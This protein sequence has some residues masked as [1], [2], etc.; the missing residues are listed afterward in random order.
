MLQKMRH[1][2]K[3]KIVTAVGFGLMV[4]ATAGIALMDVTGS[5]RGGVSQTHVAKVDGKKISNAEFS[6]L[7]QTYLQRE[8]IPPA[9]AARAGIPMQILQQE[10]NGRLF[11]RAAYDLGIIPDD[12]TAA[13]QIKQLIA[14]LT[15]KGASQKDALTQFLRAYGMSEKQLVATIKSDVATE[16]LASLLSSGVSVPKQLL[17]DALQYRHEWRRGEYFTLSAADVEKVGEPSEEDLKKAYQSMSAKFM[18]PETRTI[19][20]LT[21]N[22]KSLGVSDAKISDA[23]VR[24]YYDKKQSE[25]GTPEKRVISQTVVKDEEAAKK[26]AAA[27][28][29]K[30]AKDYKVNA[31][32]YTAA[33]LPAELSAAVFKGKAGETLAPLKSAFGWH[34]IQI[35]K[36]QPAN[37]AKYE[38]V[39][40]DIRKKLELS[41]SAEGLYEK[42]NAL[43]DMLAGG[44][45]LD[46]VAQ[47]YGAKTVTFEKI[48]AT[49]KLEGKV[50]APE[51]VLSNAFALSKGETSQMIET[52][53]GDFV[54]VEVRDITPAAPQPF[55]KVRTEV[56]T[57]WKENQL[58]DLLDK[59]ASAIMERLNMGEGF[60][61][62]AASLGKPVVK[63]DMLQRGSAAAEKNLK[64]GLL[65]ALFAI[66]RKG[67]AITVAGKESLTILRLA[68]SKTEVPTT[69]KKE[70]SEA[71]ENVLSRSM[72]NDLMEQYRQFLME[73]YN[74]TI[75]E[76]TVTQMF[77]PKDEQNQAY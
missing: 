32:T 69:P 8:K 5:F 12:A 70:D 64:P 42:A 9:E 58:A 48:T 55:D 6:R 23:D 71:L 19:G 39:A 34:V 72:Q 50:G 35:N 57:A 14:P 33:D 26:I 30:A 13:R 52:Q 22:K 16:F 7:V 53:Q 43:D 46:D 61:K 44:K 11:A 67:Q 18:L 2:V 15:Q 41:A 38:S 36:I 10:I 56:A 21:L 37:V 3:S 74:V 66:E 17:D 40:T 75:N 20:V 51:K 27:G 73:K 24:A 4:L 28:I 49:E 62:V 45:K 54:I 1:G 25:F 65:P 29:N 77:S 76:E 60:D 47:E 31:G 59:K 68:E 63:T